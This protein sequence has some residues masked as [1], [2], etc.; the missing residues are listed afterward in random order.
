MLLILT[1]AFL[2]ASVASRWTHD[3]LFDTDA[4]LDTVGPIGTEEVITDALSER[5]SDS[6]IEGLDMENRMETALPPVLAPLAGLVAPWVNDAIVEETNGFFESDFYEDAWLAINARGHAAVVA[7]IRDQLPLVSTE[8]GVVTVDLEPILSPVTDRVF[9]RLT[10]LGEVIPD[11]ILDRVDIDETVSEIMQ[12]YEE[13]GLPERLRTV[14]VYDSERL[15]AVQ[16]ATA[17]FDRLVWVLPVITIVLAA[18]A[19]YF[20]PLRGLMVVLLLGSAAV[21]WILAWFAVQLVGNAIVSSI[22]ATTTAA[23]ADEVF[24]AATDGLTTLLVWLAVVAGLASVVVGWWLY[25]GEEEEEAAN[26]PVT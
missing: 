22:D 21:G 13:E 1:T 7:I 24:T 4:W 8:G 14:Q 3:V 15:A 2:V 10:E 19:I 5:V 11:A 12:T 16:Q 25:R 9:D 18:A 17:L 20:A 23:V 26:P 6:L